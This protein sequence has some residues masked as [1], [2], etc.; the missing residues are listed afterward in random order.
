M[1]T[2]LPS[3]TPS[4][5]LENV[6][7]V[8]KPEVSTEAEEMMQASIEVV[9]ANGQRQ[10]FLNVVSPLLG[11]TRCEAGCIRCMVWKDTLDERRLHFTTEWESRSD[12]D[13]YLKSDRFRA[14]LVAAELSAEAPIIEIHTISETVGFE[15]LTDILGCESDVRSHGR[16]TDPKYP[17]GPGRRSS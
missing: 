7:A 4:A 11:P 3:G 17:K 15:Y 14:V 13:R 16:D 5:M 9:V 1:F 8:H 10:Q 12:L 2:P 6:R